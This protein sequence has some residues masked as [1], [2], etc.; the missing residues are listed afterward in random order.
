MFFSSNK[1]LLGC[2][3][4][5]PPPV[6][7]PDLRQTG[8]LSYTLP[9]QIWRFIYLCFDDEAA[10]TTTSSY[11]EDVN[12][13]VRCCL[14]VYWVESICSINYYY[15]AITCGAI[16]LNMGCNFNRDPQLLAGT[17][18]SSRSSLL[19]CNVRCVI[20]KP[21]NRVWGRVVAINIE[22]VRQIFMV[23]RWKLLTRESINLQL[24]HAYLH[25]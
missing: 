3:F 21:F 15:L 20:H 7:I 14:L 10:T 19:E 12:I 24:R 13:C 9:S 11:L 16:R 4:A 1:Q 5:P 6:T 23:A 25:T 2:G 8:L 22:T 17:T 18:P